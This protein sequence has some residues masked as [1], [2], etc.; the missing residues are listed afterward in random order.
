MEWN[1]DTFSG[2][3]STLGLQLESSSNQKVLYT[4]CHLLH[5]HQARSLGR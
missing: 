1:L 2:S 5:W 3:P 4:D